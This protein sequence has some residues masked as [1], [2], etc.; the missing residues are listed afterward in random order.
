MV[1]EGPDNEQKIKLVLQITSLSAVVKMYRKMYKIHQTILEIFVI[2][3]LY[4]DIV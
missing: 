3:L 4:N 1:L 2:F